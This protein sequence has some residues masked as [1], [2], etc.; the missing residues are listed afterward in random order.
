MG[1]LRSLID[2]L[3]GRKKEV[4]AEA[5]AKEPA[6]KA[7]IEAAFS[8]K[9]EPPVEEKVESKAEALVEEKAEVK[10]EAP[11][12]EP[13]KSETTA[14]VKEVPGEFTKIRGIG[15]A[16]EKKIKEAGIV[17]YAQLAQTKPEQL[18]K[19]TGRPVARIIDEGWV[20]Q[21]QKLVKK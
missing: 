8:P 6:A 19:I 17:T 11:V 2:A 9:V 13:A 21:A 7:P 12:E 5:P 10:V 1:F 16:T 3:T 20:A 4:V 15:A 18:A 14:A